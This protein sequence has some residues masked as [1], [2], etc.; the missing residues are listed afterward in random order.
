MISMKLTGPAA[1]RK[2]V[3]FIDPLIRLAVTCNWLNRGS[4]LA[5]I[6]PLWKRSAIC[7]RCDPG[8][9]DSRRRIPILTVMGPDATVIAGMRNAAAAFIKLLTA[10][11]PGS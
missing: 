8:L 3:L 9:T 1:W 7:R 5:L 10:A 11:G 2:V 6:R 4:A